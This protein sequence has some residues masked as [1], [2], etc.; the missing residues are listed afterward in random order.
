VLAFIP[1]TTKNDAHLAEM[2]K[3]E[4][5][6]NLER[7]FAGRMASGNR[8]NHLL[9]YA[10]ALVDSGLDLYSVQQAVLSFNGKLSNGLPEDEIRTTIFVSVSKRFS[11][12]T[13][14]AA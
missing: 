12:Q 3:I 10:M 13:A 9:K 5:M 2:K 4:S 14:A 7:W 1:K 11:K 8:N 6:D